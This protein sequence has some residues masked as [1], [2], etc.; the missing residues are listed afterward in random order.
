[1]SVLEED[2]DEEALEAEAD[3]AVQQ[4]PNPRRLVY[5]EHTTPA[6]LLPVEV[7]RCCIMCFYTKYSNFVAGEGAGGGDAGG[8]GAGAAAAIAV[9]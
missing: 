3:Q 6:T 9:A 7:C 8:G 5:P 2:F 1:M 4:V